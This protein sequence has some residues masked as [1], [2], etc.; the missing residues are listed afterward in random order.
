MR[1]YIVTCL[2]LW[3]APWTSARPS[4]C[5][6][7]S[8]GAWVQL[9]NEPCVMAARVSHQQP[10]V[11]SV[12]VTDALGGLASE[13]SVDPIA[14]GPTLS[15][16]GK[17]SRSSTK[18]AAVKCRKRGDRSPFAPWLNL[19]PRD[20]GTPLHYRSAKRQ[21]PWKARS[22]YV[23]AILQRRRSTARLASPTVHRMACSAWEPACVPHRRRLPVKRQ[24]VDCSDEELRE[25]QGT[26]LH[27]ATRYN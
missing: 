6:Y 20:F 5:C 4:C 3:Q 26:T 1:H 9:S 2:Q 24:P 13:C 18:T 7:S 10:A 23:Q 19:L 15:V 22:S 14:P 25:L 12:A 27:A 16:H 8:R 11:R 17:C 21:A